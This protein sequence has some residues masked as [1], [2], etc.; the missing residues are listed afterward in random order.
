MEKV[1]VVLKDEKSSDIRRNLGVS[2]E[3]ADQIKNKI[4]EEL[5]G[6][7]NTN[8]AQVIASVSTICD[9][10]NELAMAGFLVGEQVHP[11]FG[12]MLADMMGKV[13]QNAE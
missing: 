6:G 8:Y 10:H 4:T 1:T 13:G 11:D 5:T 2:D 7:K 9:N 3:K 12:A